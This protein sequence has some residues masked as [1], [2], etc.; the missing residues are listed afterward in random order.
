MGTVLRVCDLD[1]SRFNYQ[2]SIAVKMIVLISLLY[3][4]HAL[5]N[6]SYLNLASMRI[7]TAGLQLKESGRGASVL[8]SYCRVD[9]EAVRRILEQSSK[10]V[11][12]DPDNARRNLVRV[13]GL[14]ESCSL[15]LI[16]TQNSQAY[17]LLTKV[18]QS[19][20]S[21]EN[22]IDQSDVTEMALPSLEMGNDEG[23]ELQEPIFQVEGND[24]VNE[25]S[26]SMLISRE[27]DNRQNNRDRLVPVPPII[28]I[29]M[30]DLVVDFCPDHVDLTKYAATIRF[31]RAC[32]G[33][34]HTRAKYSSGVFSIRMRAPA[35][36]PGVSNSFYISSN[37]GAPD[38]ISFDF[39]G[40][41]PH[42][43]LTAYAVNGDH[44]Q[45]LKTFHM[46][47]DTTQEFHEYSIK[48]D[49]ETIV[50]M[51]DSI[52]I[53]T[54]RASRVKAFPVKPG[55]VFG[56]SWDASSV[57]DG[58]LAGRVNWYNA[59]FFM[60]FENFQVAS[61]LRVG[62]WRPPQQSLV[63]RNGPHPVRPL[64]IDY[65]PH[66]V[67]AANAHNYDITFDKFGCGSRVRSLHT[68]PSGKFS[69]T[70]K[71][72]DGDTSGLLTSFYISS[73]E[74]STMQDEIDFEFLGDNK[75]IVQ[76][77]FYVNGTSSGNELWVELDYDCSYGFHTYSIHYNQS[78]IQWFIDSRLVRTVT[79]EKQI[80]HQRSYPT[81]NVFLYSSVWNA[82]DVNDG[83][84]T[85]KWHGMAEEPFVAKFKSVT[86]Q[87]PA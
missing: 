25:N 72:A 34:F 31:D 10:A 71:C 86:V 28:G 53:R 75:R 2:L 11:I 40:N 23:S 12:D 61:P 41:Q 27:E 13:G 76:T 56:Y 69:A 29:S 68:Y 9:L 44:D 50:W 78:K 26:G 6:P 52:V 38:M 45:K 87:Y 35:G 77:N 7:N 64:V 17:E 74:G 83:G 36:A 70:I 62:Q 19:V 47:F 8:E 46:S 22:L 67:A 14:L 42:R 3:P 49:A 57:A 66:N 5:R 55:H 43:V 82:S 80:R 79:K 54:L 39:V 33:K 60:S 16:T 1:N 20:A 32:G 81:K 48:W 84:W 21:A 24:S 58:T 59:P 37:D 4:S 30:D 85:G 63:R 18:K 65:C 15:N 73:G 51:V